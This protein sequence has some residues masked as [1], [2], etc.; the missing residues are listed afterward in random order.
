MMTSATATVGTRVKLFD[1]TPSLHKKS[2]APRIVGFNPR[3]TPRAGG[4]RPA[5]GATVAHDRRARF[6]AVALALPLPWVAGFHS[7]RELR[8]SLPSNGPQ[9]VAM[10]KRFRHPNCSNASR[11]S[12]S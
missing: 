12:R 11:D 3:A 7:A 1:F 5:R 6:P 2:A 8:T 9:M 4:A 10:G